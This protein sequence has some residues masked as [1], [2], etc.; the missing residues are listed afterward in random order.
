MM[1]HSGKTGAQRGTSKREDLLDTVIHLKHPADYDPSQGARFEL[2]FEKARGF[3]GQ[4]AA[5]LEVQYATQGGMPGAP[6][7]WTW[8]DLTQAMTEQ[9]AALLKQGLS[10]G[11]IAKELNIG[12]ATVNRHAQKAKESGL[13][14]GK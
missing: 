5:P 9:V 14:S 3:F 1:H 13:W 4:D 8:K 11:A 6:A 10:Q 12:K 7:L 2:H